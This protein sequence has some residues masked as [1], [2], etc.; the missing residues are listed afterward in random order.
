MENQSLE[1]FGINIGALKSVFSK[2]FKP[3]NKFQTKVLLSDDSSRIFPSIICYSKDHRLVGETAKSLYKKFV[4]NSYTDLIRL[5]NLYEEKIKPHEIEFMN[6]GS[7]K[8]EKLI[9]FENETLSPSEI[10]ADYLSLIIKFY[11]EQ[12]IIIDNCVISVPDF[13]L[14]YQRNLLKTICN[15]VGI[16]NIKVINESTAIT[17]YYGYSKYKDMFVSEKINV[18]SGIKKD[19][20]FIDIGHSKTSFIYSTFNYEKFKVRYVKCIPFLGGRNFNIKIKDEC[21]KYFINK[22]KNYKIEDISKKSIARLFEVIEK[23]RIKLTVNKEIIILV[24]SFHD[25]EDLE[26]H[27]TKE[28]FEKLIKEELE[29]FKNKFKEFKD[30]LI[31]INNGIIPE[32]LNIEMAG[33]LFRTPILQDIITQFFNNTIQISKTIIVDEC[34]S[35]GAALMSYYI[36]N[37]NNFPISTFKKIEGYIYNQIEYDNQL[38]LSTDKMNNLFIPQN[39]I[40]EYSNKILSLS[41]N[42]CDKTLAY[43]LKIDLNKIKIEKE[44]KLLIKNYNSED[45]ISVFIYKDKNTYLPLKK[46]DE[47]FI[48]FVPN[49][50][51]DFKK[52]LNEHE[53][54]EIKY[55][56][57]LDLI[58]DIFPKFYQK[59]SKAK[60]I[61]T[62]SIIDFISLKE[63]ELKKI[64]NKKILIPKIDELL[65]FRQEQFPNIDNEIEKRY[66][67]VKKE[68]INE[69]KNDE[70]V[71]NQDKIKIENHDLINKKEENNNNNRNIKNDNVLDNKKNNEIKNDNENHNEL[72]NNRKIK[73][74]NE[75]IKN[76]NV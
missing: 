45:E 73:L 3:D 19:I 66:K 67:K 33:D 35:V 27:L 56:E 17:M 72:N 48:E 11:K 22:Y 47:Y 20:I 13:F 40:N 30:E 71:Q 41:F 69:N 18:N 5:F 63:S 12:N 61:N 65:K 29:I 32:N 4:H 62:Q 7:F 54:K 55:Y 76:D 15:A 14:E 58:N 57:Y 44:N 46:K 31:K 50:I 2:C 39:I 16:E 60:N 64:Q 59:K 52:S 74:Q 10:V 70:Q 28:N 8:G 24:E 23:E 38:K 25:N 6:F 37:N 36:Y 42:Y 9:G 26:F 53:N 51:I 43:F 34:T 21:I 1:T 75:E 49:L 68:Q